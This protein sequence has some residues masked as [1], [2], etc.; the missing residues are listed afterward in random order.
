MA[1]TDGLLSV[2][3]SDQVGLVRL[4]RADRLNAL[5]PALLVALRET[6]NQLPRR[7]ARVIVLTGS[8][9]AFSSGA[10][11]VG[12]DGSSGMPDDLGALLQ[13]YYTPLVEEIWR[14][15]VPILCA[16]NGPA[17]GAGCSLALSGDLIFAAESAYFLQSFI[18]IGLVPD[19]GSTWMLPRLVGTARAMEMMLLG[20]RIPASQALQWGLI[21]RV[22]DN[23][24][25]LEETLAVARKIAG[26]PS[27]AYGLLRQV[28][29][30]AL[31][32]SL[33]DTLLAEASAQRAAGRTPE[34]A[35]A[36]KQ[37]ADKSRRTS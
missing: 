13:D 37:F 27:E 21:N 25:L 16:V 34:F 35:A 4:D 18:N 11:L 7:G 22:V 1:M 31:E 28:R 3:V 5:S 2:E 15:P 19:A 20:E 30:H 26:G 12:A 24:M 10:D 14:A 36:V 9:R 6:I 29:R 23:D 33:S 32:H 17:A 8:G